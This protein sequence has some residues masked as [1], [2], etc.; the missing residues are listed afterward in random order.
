MG[1]SLKQT[2]VVDELT[3]DLTKRHC[4]NQDLNP[5]LFRRQSALENV[6]NAVEVSEDKKK[7]GRSDEK[8]AM[9][10]TDL[11]IFVQDYCLFY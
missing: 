9:H 4:H 10:L 2:A 3:V 6:W 5:G 7:L 8:Y 11:L 1:N